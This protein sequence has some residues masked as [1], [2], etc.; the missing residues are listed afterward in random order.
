[1]KERS[2]R[3]EMALI[4]S[5]LAAMSFVM[6]L[7]M[8]SVA[9]ANEKPSVSSSRATQ[10][11]AATAGKSVD[12]AKEDAATIANAL[13]SATGD[14]EKQATVYGQ[15]DK[16]YESLD[17]D[18]ESLK[19]A[20][21]SADKSQVAQLQRYANAV[22]NIMETLEAEAVILNA[23]TKVSESYSSATIDKHYKTL[24][25][26]SNELGNYQGPEYCKHL[27]DDYV[28]KVLKPQIAATKYLYKFD[29]GKKSDAGYSVLGAF[30]VQQLSE[31]T[32][33]AT[34]QLASTWNGIVDGQ[35]K[36]SEAA[37]LDQVDDSLRWKADAA[38]E[39]SPNL[40]PSMDSVTNLWLWSADAGTKITAS[41]EVVGFTQKWEETL[42]LNQGVNLYR[43]KP[44]VLAN[45]TSKDLQ[46][47]KDT[48]IELRIT[49]G[50]GSKQLAKKSYK[51]KIRD[52]YAFDWETDEF[53]VTSAFNILAW[54][55]PNCE[56]VDEVIRIANEYMQQ[57]TGK[58]MAGYQFGDEDYLG[59]ILQAAA[60][61]SAIS[62]E[63]VRYQM[64]NYSLLGEQNILTP[65]AVIAKKQGLCIETTLLMASCLKRMGMHPL[66]I[67]TPGHAQC[68]VELSSESGNYYLLETTSLPYQVNTNS[69][70]NTT[71][72]YNDLLV[73]EITSG[74]AEEWK[75]YLASK[76]SDELKAQGDP[77][78]GIFVIDCDMEEDLGISGLDV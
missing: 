7:C 23:S 21:A 67:L 65:D 48:Q 24:T 15:M 22:N 19:A 64:D 43:I 8:S 66:L 56:Q 68:A 53:G 3:L 20:A 62:H 9:V 27:F 46:K 49:N 45:L 29:V 47:N 77:F 4:K 52:M 60:I 40:Y 59:T 16:L 76:Y 54:M 30:E 42:T 32:E 35:Y 26:L 25:E 33:R 13:Y 63:G 12:E 55:R 18:Y 74:N 14:Q 38:S 37:L 10:S 34:S 41:I 6:C 1:M 36:E 78:G 61:Q 5:V 70:L 75:T 69:G 73:P 71:E 57:W 50:D 2:V 72:F 31:W 51:V 17:E 58:P 28:N 39:I 11:N 44:A